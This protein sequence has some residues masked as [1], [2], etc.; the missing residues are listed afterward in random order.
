MRKVLLLIF[1]VVF[2]IWSSQAQTVNKGTTKKQVPQIGTINWSIDPFEQAVFVENRGQFDTILPGEKIFFEA[3]LGAIVAF[4]T[5]RGI[6]YMHQ[7]TEPLD[8]SDGT[9]PDQDGPPKTYY[10]YLT[11]AW[12]GA[13]PN[14]TIDA[15]ITDKLSYYYT[16]PKGTHDTY[17]ANVFKKITYHN[18]YPGIDIV[19]SFSFGS[20]NLEYTIIVHPGADLDDV[21]L[22]YQNS[23]GMYLDASGNV[24]ENN[25][26]GILKETPPVSYY[27]E[28]H[29]SVQVSSQA[30]NP[31]ESYVANNFDATKT[32]I[33]DP[34][35]L[36][37]TNPTFL[38]NGRAE[39]YA[40]DL[41]YDNLGNIYVYGGGAG[42]N[43]GTPLQLVKLNPAGAIQWNFHATTMTASTNFYGDFA[44]DKHS[45]ECY[46]VEGWNSGGGGRVE[47]VSP[48]GALI[49]TSPATNHAFNELWR[50][51]STVCP[52][53]FVIFGNGVCCPQQAGMLD[54]TMTTPVTGVN[55]LGPTVTQG[56]HD[57]AL[58]AADPMG[59]AAWTAT[60]QSLSFIPVF[61]NYLVK[62]P[63]PTLTPN[64]YCVPDGFAFH[65]IGSIMYSPGLTFN[66]MNGLACSVAWLYAYNGDTLKQINKATGAIN[67]VTRVN[68]GGRY[69]FGGLDVD[70]CGNPY[71]GNGDTID[72]YD[73]NTLTISAT[74]PFL[75][76][77]VYDL[78]VAPYQSQLVY[79]CGRRFVSSI[80]LGPPIPQPITITKGPVTCTPCS[81]VATATL[82][83]CGSPATGPNVSYLWSDGETTQTATTLCTGVDTVAITVECEV[84][85]KDT[86]TIT[87]GGG[88]F[89]V[90]RDS[91]AAGCNNPGNAGVELS[92]GHPPYAYRWN[93]GSISS[94]TGP[95]D[96]GSYCVNISDA[97]GCSSSLC[98]SVPGVPV[99][100]SLFKT[101]I[102]Q[103]CSPLCIQFNDLST[104]PLGNI[105]QW[106]WKFGNGDTSDKQNPIYCYPKPGNYSVSLT[107]TSDHGC[108]ATLNKLNII[109]IYSNPAASFILSPQP[110][111]ILQPTIQFTDKS[112]D[113]YG[114]AEWN[115]TFGDA[116][117]SISKKQNPSH[118]Y[119]DTGTYCAKLGVMNIYGCV[120]TT[121]NCLV[122]DPIFTLYIPAA[123]T[124]IGKENKVFMAKGNDIKNFEMYIFDR[125][126]M[127]LFHSTD[128]NEGWNGTF[129]SVTSQED[130]YIYVITATDNK[131]NK[132]TYT[133]TVTLL[134]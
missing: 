105:L 56:Y 59:G 54:T 116:S 47:K 3:K 57:M 21:H 96:S 9:D 38:N 35:I 20:N 46:T 11:T 62:I 14:A 81:G 48:A 98:I 88:Q 117:D 82:N 118:T 90:M 23:N 97:Y 13:N 30:N 104:V 53:G 133:G 49:A 5:N 4:F 91:T 7:E 131:N 77:T 95:V 71:V 83:L 33:I 114:V 73:P 111:D 99:P 22:K 28:N 107:V 64:T 40:Y 63:L 43:G 79:A 61:N 32:L 10:Y 1:S 17:F 119:S 19:Y 27:M 51:E 39:D 122:I 8:F 15:D 70:L 36:W 16:Y 87:S 110:T 100:S 132:H 55:I 134:K 108:S 50:I 102:T 112:T 127:E 37:T 85:F 106:T 2:G 25:D 120:D 26:I 44:V 126:G 128:I 45:L 109:T 93:N 66:A 18:L 12:Q 115:W 29:V 65:E 75:N 6:I 123:F 84:Y 69:K 68:A 101:D 34:T 94:N 76:D 58:T 130:S 42:S 78:A 41:D 113:V 60:T 74:L 124:P 103:G 24:I 121:I 31:D 92:G 67:A 72:I 129:K 52:P 125:W 86:V 80:S 89:I